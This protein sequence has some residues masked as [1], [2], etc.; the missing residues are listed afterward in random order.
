MSTIKDRGLKPSPDDEIDWSG[1]GQH[2][3]YEPNKDVPDLK[4]GKMIASSKTAYVQEVLCRGIKLARKTIYTR[5]MSVEDAL[6]EVAHLQKLNHAHVVQLVGTYL[7][8]QEFSILLYPRAEWDLYQFLRTEDVDREE[9][10]LY[11]SRAMI[12]LV[13]A[14]DYIHRNT[15][16]HM[17]IKPSSVIH[18]PVLDIKCLL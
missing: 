7:Q 1:K 3:E 10:A 12:C 17:D 13:S 15:I 9:R 16:R 4:V 11:L 18:L 6:C 2:V 14:V 8:G 5:L